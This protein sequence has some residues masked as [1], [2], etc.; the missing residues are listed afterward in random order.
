MPCALFIGYN[1]PKLA[2][3]T[4]YRLR[5]ADPLYIFLDGNA[6]T[7]SRRAYLELIDS[8]IKDRKHARTELLLSDKNLGPMEGPWKA[9]RW[10]LEKEGEAAI[11]EEDILIEPEF[12]QAYW[13]GLKTF[14]ENKAILALSSSTKT[15]RIPHGTS[16]WFHQKLLLVWGWATWWDRIQNIEAPHTLW[17]TDRKPILGNLE[18]LLGKLYLGREFD[19]LA[20]N[21]NYAWSYYIQQHLLAHDKFTLGPA[22]KL[23]HNLGVGTG[24]LRTKQGKDGQPDPQKS[25]EMIQNLPNPPEPYSRKTERALEKEKFGSLLHEIRNRLQIKTRIKNLLPP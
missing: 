25:R 1:R 17:K 4:L 8:T 6:P 12:L 21:P 18:T 23:T 5:N 16:P 20:R 19:M 10:A 13:H 11:V 9:I 2:E 15:P 3:R 22:A 24:S 14:R 7:Q